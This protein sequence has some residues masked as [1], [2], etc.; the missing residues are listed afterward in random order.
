[1]TQDLT[2]HLYESGGNTQLPL[3]ETQ[4]TT[5][6]RVVADPAQGS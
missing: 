4:V 3:D 1:M 6:I 2:K 5:T